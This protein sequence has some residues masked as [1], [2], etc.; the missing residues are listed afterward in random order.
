[1]PRLA[2]RP[3]LLYLIFFV[4]GAAGLGYQMVW[5]RQ[6]AIGLG[7][8]VPSLVSVMAAFLGGMA[9]GAWFLDRF[10]STSPAPGHW[11]AALEF[12]MAGWGVTMALWIPRLNRTAL[13][14][15]GPD[16]SAARYWALVFAIPFAALL[17]ATLCMGATLPAM[18]RFLAPLKPDQR[19]VGAFYAANTFGAVGGTLAT[20]FFLTPALGFRASGFV[21]AGLNLLC[22][23]AA[24]ALARTLRE[25]R[26]FRE[27]VSVATAVVTGSRSL[28]TSSSRPGKN[29]HTAATVES[30]TSEALFPGSVRLILFATGLLGVGYELVGVRVLSQ[31]L[32]NTIYSF[33]AVLAVYLVG[34]ATGAA[35]YQ[36][37]GREIPF[38]SF[39]TGSLIALSSACLIGI[40]ILHHSPELYGFSRSRCGDSV[41][42][43]LFAEMAVAAAVFA[44]PAV[45]MGATFSHL[46]QAAR[47]RDQ[48]VGQAAAL[49][50]IGCA[51]AGLIFIVGL[52]PVLGAK[53]T[54]A[55]I[56]L[57]Y[58]LLIPWRNGRGWWL[59]ILVPI[60]IL[61]LL[62][63]NLRLLRLPAG[64]RIIEYREGAMGSVAV[65]QTP[66]LHRSLRVNNRFQMGGTAAA[67][68]E[69]RQ[70]HIPLLLHDSPRRALFLGPGTGI[71][72]GAA[73]AY[74]NL[75]SD[76]VELLPE[77]VAAMS[78]FEPENNG[79]FP[80]AAAGVTVADARRF[81]RT[82]TNRYDVIVGD[83][84]HPAQDGAAFLYTVEHF[85]AIR[86]RLTAGG[87][88]CQWLPLHQLDETTLRVIVRSFQKVFPDAQAWLLHFNVDI[89][90]LGLIGSRSALRFPA[91]GLERRVRDAELQQHLRAVN[92]DHT[93]NLLGCFAAGP[94]ALQKFALG[95]PLNTDDHPVVAFQ[96]PQIA[97]RHGV[98]PGDLLL[99]FLARSG[100]NARDVVLRAS[101]GKNIETFVT[102]LDDF[103]AARDL[104]LK[105]LDEEG[106]GN[107]SKAIDLYLT[108]AARSLYFTPAYARCLTIIQLTAVTDRKAARNLL[109]RLEKAQPAQPLSR[110]LREQLF[111]SE[112]RP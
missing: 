17:P 47:R 109:D 88:L 67:V 64:A 49:N 15:V 77:I 4:S 57:G 85:E 26:S 60:G 13:E 105:G 9:L 81:V 19:C 45:L 23:F 34:I 5:V 35:A 32:E 10:I 87:I 101:G 42:A 103:L 69:R 98:R 91:D 66:D 93:I 71:T 63:G 92:L 31:V 46:V 100:A 112:P 21:L 6:F 8:E 89:P 90:V 80:N 68:A 83:L 65:I 40:R 37:L 73:T 104:Y 16:P 102:N 72:L 86:S 56:G 2:L 30:F 14:L 52:L 97:Y 70:A 79:P 58:L 55:A 29:A 99:N 54:L 76:A 50:T 7:H 110:T 62:P 22:G 61:L 12:V 43:V 18:D 94:D 111:E 106:A 11:Y 44:L 96:A 27:T 82:T 107:L 33:A 75:V 74:T 95:A 38:R 3:S 59:G 53:W 28:D 108:S 84:F 48:G 25:Q 39:L 78:A 51:S 41:T 36:R 1:M 20:V 24:L